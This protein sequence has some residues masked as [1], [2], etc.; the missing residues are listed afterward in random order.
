METI[1]EYLYKNLKNCLIEQPELNNED[2]DVY[3]ISHITDSLITILI[4]MKLTN[5]DG[6][7]IFLYNDGIIVLYKPLN[8]RRLY[9]RNHCIKID[10]SR[11]I[12][13]EFFKMK[14]FL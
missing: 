6:N 2:K 5:I 12:F 13:F 7:S 4:D 3:E 14:Y 8:N 9:R 1:D 10:I 11:T